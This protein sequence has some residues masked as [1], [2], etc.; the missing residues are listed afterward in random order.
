MEKYM[1]K[2]FHE[3]I[4]S[5]SKKNYETRLALESQREESHLQKIQDAIDIV[6]DIILSGE[7]RQ[8]ITDA[9]YKGYRTCKVFEF[10]STCKQ[11][12]FHLV[13]LFYGPKKDKGHGKGLKFFEN[14]EIVSLMKR[15]SVELA[16]FEVSLTCRRAAH[17][18]IQSLY[19]SW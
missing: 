7:Y 10:E 12:E 5:L 17:K 18:R 1:L 6:V 9:A 16:P 14:I 13:F 19:L 8:F 3:Q 15:L 2:T 11:D 4:V